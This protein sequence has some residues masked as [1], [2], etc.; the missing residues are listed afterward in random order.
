MG[1]MAPGK[2]VWAEKRYMPGKDRGGLRT[3]G[4]M[5]KLCVFRPHLPPAESALPGRDLETVL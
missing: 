1:M 2:G 3:P 4:L 5:S